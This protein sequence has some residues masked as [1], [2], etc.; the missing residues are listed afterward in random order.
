MKKYND[1]LNITLIFVSFA[2]YF[3]L[4]A[5]TRSQTGLFS[6]AASALIS[7]AHSHLQQDQNDETTTLLR[8]L[9]HK[10]DDTTL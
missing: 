7:K 8:V 9:I 3:G 4:H 5:L 2:W 6:A 10:I 1:D